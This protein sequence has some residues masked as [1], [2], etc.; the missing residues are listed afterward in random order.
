MQRQQTR[1]ALAYSTVQ[2][3]V[4][5]TVRRQLQ[6]KAPCCKQGS[7]EVVSCF[8]VPR[9]CRSIAVC[10]CS[11]AVLCCTSVLG[12]FCKKQRPSANL[13]AISACEKSA[14]AAGGESLA[15]MQQTLFCLASLLLS[16][17]RCCQMSFLSQPPSVL[18]RKAG[19]GNKH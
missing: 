3:G 15:E 11:Q 14:M 9:S 13:A 10:T 18:V 12:L 2:G 16:R 1:A 7:Q 6:L 5:N 17:D 8:V 19:N 4:E